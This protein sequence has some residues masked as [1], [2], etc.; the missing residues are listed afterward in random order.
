LKHAP[1]SQKTEPAED[2]ADPASDQAVGNVKNDPP[3]RC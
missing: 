3:A 2:R 1:D